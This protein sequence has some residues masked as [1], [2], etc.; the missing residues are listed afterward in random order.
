M[1]G[2][3]GKAS[4]KNVR[5]TRASQRHSVSV[6]R[7]S[8][9]TRSPRAFIRAHQI[10]LAGAHGDLLPKSRLFS[11]VAQQ[12]IHIGKITQPMAQLFVLE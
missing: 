10:Q 2:P 9:Q 12:A 6:F 7:E 5:P 4:D 3:H 11:K 8:T 1:S